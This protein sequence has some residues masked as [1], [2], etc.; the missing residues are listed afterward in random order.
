MLD[1]LRDHPELVEDLEIVDFLEECYH[2]A[3]E[4]DPDEA[5]E[6]L[7]S[8]GLLLQTM[9]ED[10]HVF[11]EL[12]AKL[13]ENVKVATYQQAFAALEDAAR[14]GYA[15]GMVLTAWSHFHGKGTPKDITSAR[16][17]FDLASKREVGDSVML[18]NLRAELEEAQVLG[19]DS[20]PRMN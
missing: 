7:Y 8:F 17:W 14:R 13:D 9:L 6:Y 15:D 16:Y 5:P 3:L 2:G 12:Q 19:N 20:K 4:E 1:Y 10:F 18:E 11:G